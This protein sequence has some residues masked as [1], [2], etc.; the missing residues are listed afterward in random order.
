MP[1][2]VGNKVQ[3]VL[4]HL[5]KEKIKRVIILVVESCAESKVVKYVFGFVIQVKRYGLGETF[6]LHSNH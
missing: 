2:V 1:L 5:G 3:Q 4:C 6:V